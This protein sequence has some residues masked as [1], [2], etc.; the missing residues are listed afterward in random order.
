MDDTELAGCGVAGMKQIS[1]DSI[2]PGF[3]V[4]WEIC[5]HP[6][7]QGQLKPHLTLLYIYL[8]VY[9]DQDT[10]TI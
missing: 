3:I 2:Y 1:K 7:E 10:Q 6:L 4:I 9:Y 8:G 5:C